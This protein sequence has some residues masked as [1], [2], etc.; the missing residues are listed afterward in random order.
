VIVQSMGFGV[1]SVTIAAMACL[2]DLPMPDACIFADPR[3]ESKATYR[4]IETFTP[5]AKQRGLD[6]TT[7]SKGNI[8][9]DAAGSQNGFASLPLHTLLDGQ[10]GMLR[11]QCTNEYKIQPVIQE[12]RRQLGV[13]KR[14]RVKGKVTLWLGISLDE[15][16]RMKESLIPWIENAWP[17]V[18]KKMRRGDCIE[19]LKTHGI[20]VPPKSSCIGCP[21]HGD[22][23]WRDLKQN[24]P[25]EFESACNFDDIM[26]TRKAAV[27]APVFLHP[28]LK[29]LRDVDFNDKQ[30]DMFAN[31]CEGH[32]GL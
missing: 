15:V 8:R 32:C 7:V 13:E 23:Y 9:A 18:E 2:G 12:I 24:S 29:P 11:R 26:R 6:I 21:F 25:E 19:Y 16:E 20:P 27:K 28:S 22:A 5:W 14:K 17:L 31:E 1:Q 30:G 3:W 4:Y 10:P